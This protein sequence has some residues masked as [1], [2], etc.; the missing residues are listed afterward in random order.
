MPAHKR[1]FRRRKLEA[2]IAARARPQPLKMAETAEDGPAV[3]PAMPPTLLEMMVSFFGLVK[4]AT[5]DE[6]EVYEQ[7]TQLFTK[8][9]VLTLCLLSVV[10]SLPAAATPNESREQQLETESQ[11]QQLSESLRPEDRTIF[12]HVYT[13]IDPFYG[14]TYGG[15]VVAELQRGRLRLEVGYWE[16]GGGG[17]G[18]GVSCQLSWQ[19]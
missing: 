12:D 15:R 13:G 19:P 17:G 1:A 6:P 11:I 9:S 4:R 5:V 2:V 3:T 7:M 18:G 8:L 14:S 16:D 10:P